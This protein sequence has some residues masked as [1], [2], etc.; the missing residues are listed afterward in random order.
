MLIPV[1]YIKHKESH[2]M[3][4]TPAFEMSQLSRAGTAA[5]SEL[6]CDIMEAL[7]AGASAG[8]Y[9]SGSITYTGPDQD[10]LVRIQDELKQQGYT[11]T[12]DSTTAFTITW[13]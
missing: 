10:S 5:D 7:Y 6:R 11:V 2:K 12:I 1:K 4:F 8:N 13:Q 9:T 3:T